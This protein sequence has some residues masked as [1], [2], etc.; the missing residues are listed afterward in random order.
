M[1]CSFG[2]HGISFSC[3][4]TLSNFLSVPAGIQVPGGLAMVPS[5]CPG[6]VMFV[7]VVYS[8]HSQV[9]FSFIVPLGSPSMLVFRTTVKVAVN[10]PVS[11]FGVVF[12]PRTITASALQQ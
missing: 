7:A 12:L 1:V 9:H 3:L 8:H 5:G 10:F 6:Q 11:P 4:F 2:V